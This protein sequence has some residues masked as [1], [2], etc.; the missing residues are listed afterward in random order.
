MSP[1]SEREQRICAQKNDH[2]RVKSLFSANRSVKIDTEF[3]MPDSDL[4]FCG[5]NLT[6]IERLLKIGASISYTNGQVKGGTLAHYAV[7]RKL[8][9]LIPALKR[10]G[11]NLSEA[12][13]DGRAPLRIA[14]SQGNLEMVKVLLDN[15]ADP[16]A[17][18]PDGFSALHLAVEKWFSDAVAVLSGNGADVNAT[19]KRGRTPLALAAEANN[20]DCVEILM[21]SGTISGAVVTEIL[22]NAVERNAFKLVQKLLEG[23]ASA[24]QKYPLKTPHQ[25]EPLGYYIKMGIYHEDPVEATPIHFAYACADEEMVKLLLDY[26]AD[27][28]VEFGGSFDTPIKIAIVRRKASLMRLLLKIGGTIRDRGYL[29]HLAML[30]GSCD[31][32]EVLLENGCDVNFQDAGDY[33]LLR[34]AFIFQDENCLE[35]IM[36][37]GVSLSFSELVALNFLHCVFLEKILSYYLADLEEPAESEV[38]TFFESI[39]LPDWDWS[40]YSTREEGDEAKMDYQR[41]AR[42]SVKV[43]VRHLVKLKVLGKKINED[44][45]PASLSGY[46]KLGTFQAKCEHELKRIKE[47]VVRKNAVSYH[48]PLTKDLHSVCRCLGNEKLRRKLH[49]HDYHS[50]FPLYGRIISCRVKLGSWRREFFIGGMKAF[51]RLVIRLPKLPRELKEDILQFLSIQDLIRLRLLFPS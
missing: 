38:R 24:N 34:A 28:N 48:D 8:F 50:E 22:F 29:L 6:L 16:N 10:S 3:I 12:Q 41:A 45:I 49:F 40:R 7:Q 31:A 42:T 33:K 23:G 20:V 43:F 37:Y 27:P 35:M 5:Q 46:F 36:K 17:Q 32:V 1:P 13:S 30:K 15:G 4:V 51:N 18:T 39:D 47:T 9:S 19:D 26:G 14:V 2:P 11:V 21:R 25:F 44:L